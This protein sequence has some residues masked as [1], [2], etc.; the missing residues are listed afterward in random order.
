MWTT[1]EVIVKKLGK[2][3]LKPCRLVGLFLMGEENG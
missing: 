2:R 1:K 3:D